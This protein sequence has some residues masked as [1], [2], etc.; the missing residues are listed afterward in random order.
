MVFSIL[1]FAGFEGRR[2]ARRGDHPSAAQYSRSRLLGTVLGS[3]L[4]FVFVAYCE[5]IGFGP[6]GIK[7]LANSEAPLNDLALR[8][9]SPRLAIALDL[10][11]A[12]SCFS[13]MLGGL[14]AGGAH[15][16]R[17]GPRRTLA[18]ARR[19]ASG[20]WH[21]RAGRVRSPRS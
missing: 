4:F 1:C 11:A 17:V 16:V 21:A 9:A 19:R 10:A 8:Y 7:D 2:D 18:D 20:A 14:A 5:V 12:T 15:S 3:G 6:G 13:G